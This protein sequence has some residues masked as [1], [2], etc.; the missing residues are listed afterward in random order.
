MESWKNFPFPPWTPAYRPPT[1]SIQLTIRLSKRPTSCSQ[2]HTRIDDFSNQLGNNSPLRMFIG[3]NSLLI[4]PLASS[5][6]IY[7][8]YVTRIAILPQKHHKQTGSNRV[9][10]F[11]S[12]SPKIS[13]FVVFHQQAIH[14]H[15]VQPHPW[16]Q[17]GLPNTLSSQN[18]CQPLTHFSHLYFSH[19]FNPLP[20]YLFS[21]RILS[22]HTTIFT[23]C[24]QYHH[25]WNSINLFIF[26]LSH[27]TATTI[28]PPPHHHHHH[29]HHITHLP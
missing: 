22:T 12:R 23:Q 13:L 16:P 2:Y 29:H 3:P 14:T 26:I 28:T 1:G 24:P 20:P 25:N 27:I 7:P 21:P 8:T 5:P 19:L 18:R 17:Y 4:M 15:L 10:F 11:S 6:P 9:Q